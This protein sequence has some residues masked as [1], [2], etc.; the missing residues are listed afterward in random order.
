MFFQNRQKNLS[1]NFIDRRLLLRNPSILLALFTTFYFC[2]F[3]D[4]REISD[5][6]RETVLATD[7]SVLPKGSY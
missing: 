1:F 5:I 6:P 2:T 4:S 3:L 7:W